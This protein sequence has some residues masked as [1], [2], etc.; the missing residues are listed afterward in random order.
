MI[1]ELA[2]TLG[3]NIDKKFLEKITFSKTAKIL[4]K[5]FKKI[6]LMLRRHVPMLQYHKNKNSI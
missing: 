3:I 5:I 2:N 6:Q 1:F 4:Q